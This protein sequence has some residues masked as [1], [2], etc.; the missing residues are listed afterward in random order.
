MIA[1]SPGQ[2]SSY[3]FSLRKHQ[4]PISPQ[5]RTNRSTSKTNQMETISENKILDI[6][7]IPNHPHQKKTLATSIVFPQEIDCVSDSQTKV[8]Q[9]PG[10]YSI[11]LISN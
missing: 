11:S 5:Q 8:N 4:Q 9:Q 10:C 6:F 2:D 7:R 3:E 1:T